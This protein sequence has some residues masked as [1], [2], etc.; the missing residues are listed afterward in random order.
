[1]PNSL[2][3]HRGRGYDFVVIS[4][5]PK[6]IL[7]DPQGRLHSLEGKAIEWPDGWGLYMVHG[8]QVPAEWIEDKESLTPEKALREQNIELRRAA[9]EI[10][11]WGTVL[12]KLNARVVDEDSDPAIGTLLVCDLPG[13]SNEY[14]LRVRCA[15]GRDFI[16]PVP[17]AKTALEANAAT[18]GLTSKEYRQLEVRT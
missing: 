1:M 11:G 3:R 2:S 5:R 6:H 18:Y 7:R 14:F 13:A 9:M 8:T 17:P 16:L 12:E 4:D 15:T 10:V